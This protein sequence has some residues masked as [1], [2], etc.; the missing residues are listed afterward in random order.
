MVI[1]PECENPSRINF[2]QYKDKVSDS[3]WV[4]KIQYKGLGI[5]TFN[6]FK[7]KLYEIMMRNINIYFH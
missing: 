6:D 7:I 3:Y 4:G 2:G 1:I 5:F